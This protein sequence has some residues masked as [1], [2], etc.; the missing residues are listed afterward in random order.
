MDSELLIMAPHALDFPEDRLGTRVGRSIIEKIVQK[1][2]GLRKISA[3]IRQTRGVPVELPAANL[4]L[5]HEPRLRAHTSQTIPIGRLLAPNIRGVILSYSRLRPEPIN[6]K[7]KSPARIP[8]HNS[9]ARVQLEPDA[10][11]TPHKQLAFQRVTFLLF[12]SLCGEGG[13]FSSLAKLLWRGAGVWA[14]SFLL[15][16]AASAAPAEPSR[17]HLEAK[18]VARAHRALRVEGEAPKPPWRAEEG[19]ERGRKPPGS[20]GFNERKAC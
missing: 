3:D 14:R 12:A 20:H 2:Y 17:R 4:I 1:I 15:A 8:H 11:P 6:P 7:T 16:P 9:S 13:G 19:G 5:T 10:T 18:A